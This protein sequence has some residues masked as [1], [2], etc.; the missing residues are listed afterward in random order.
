MQDDLTAANAANAA[1]PAPTR[2]WPRGRIGI[3][4]LLLCVA[5]YLAL[6]HNL[7]F[8][9][10]VLRGLPGEWGVQQ[11]GLS[12]ALF[13]AVNVL[14]LLAMSIFSARVLIKPMLTLFLLIASAC[15]YFMDSFG[16]VI[17][18]SMIVNALQTNVREAS[19]LL[20]LP[21]FIHIFVF[22]LIPSVLVWRVEILGGSR[23]GEVL[24]RLLL[25][26]LALIALV[27]AVMTN[28]KSLTL[29][30]RA[31]REIRL[32]VNPTYPIY[33]AS[34]HLK[35]AVYNAPE[36]PLVIVG[37]DATRHP[38]ASGKPR[39]V[40]M[41]VGETARAAN[42]QLA[43]Y[44]R[45]TNPE[46][47]AIDGVVSLNQ[48]W[49]C[50]TATAV[51]VPC[52]FSRL[53]RE[54][55]SR[56]KAR[57]EENLLDVLQR[58]GVAVQWR[59]N[60]SDSKGVAA[61]VPSENFR[62]R[63]T[64]GVCGAEGCHDE[65]LLEGL[66]ELLAG[67]SEDRFIVL[68]L[69]G[70]HGPSY[71]KRYPPEFRRFVPDCAQDD[72]QSCSR[73]DI[74]NAYDNTMLYTDH[75]LARV[76]GVLARHQ[77]RIEP[78]LIYMSD[79]GESLGENGIYLHGLPYAVAPDEQKHVPGVVWSP[80]LDRSC[81]ESRRDGVYSHDNL[82]HTVLGLFEISTAEYRAGADILSGCK[83]T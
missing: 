25:V 53:G 29:W 52:M 21:M 54:S 32:Y 3:N 31:H 19:E 12:A 2:R 39:V 8:W 37:A 59:D 80:G 70:S 65:V 46:L 57:E 47:A 44:A 1:R 18:E 76:I 40:V 69:L 20:G 5:L 58:T 78:T 73:E 24:R 64:A 17:D 77:D 23:L 56:S 75:V 55:F 28:Y 66:D 26:A 36:R 74:V 38:A 60:N 62:N 6:T 9:R 4:S 67:G 34:K 43:G 14:L 11:Y 50:G 82:F 30:A 27:S 49:S 10:Q 15:G 45:A 81:L 48:L 51:S 22:G 41:A 35:E 79:H 71:Y 16:V 42:F 7:S 68:H 13:V 72:V 63:R 33:A 61:R 83:R